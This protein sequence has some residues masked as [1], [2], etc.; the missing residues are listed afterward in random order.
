MNPIRKAIDPEKATVAT[1]SPHVASPPESSKA[2]MRLFDPVKEN[3]RPIRPARPPRPMPQTIQDCCDLFVK[4]K[5]AL[6]ALGAY[7]EKSFDRLK[8]S[9]A[10]FCEFIGDMLV[11]DARQSDL[12]DWLNTNTLWKNPH[13]LQA[14]AGY[15][16]SAFRFVAKEGLIQRCPFYRNA[17]LFPVA[18][19][20]EDLKPEEYQA[21]MRVSRVTP[22]FR[23][24]RRGP[25]KPKAE[26]R[27]GRRY[28][29]NRLH[30]PSSRA[31]RR[32][33]CF[34][35]ETGARVGE[36]MAM[37]WS[38]VDL[39]KSIV[40]LYYHK[41]VRKS[42]DSRIIAFPAKIKRLFV[43]TL[44]HSRIRP[45]PEDHVF[46]NGRGYPWNPVQFNQTFRKRRKMAG[47][48]R[49]ISAYSTRHGFC[50]RALEAGVPQRQIA[51]MM[52]QA[53]TRYVAWY[54]KGARKNV[55]Y[56]HGTLAQMNGKGSKPNFDG[57]AKGGES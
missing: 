7:S 41:T 33:F 19:P 26:A 18:M 55:E 22:Y 15:I 8:R 32:L 44:R 30:R 14:N 50:V 25:R 12:V 6:R 11:T 24:S 13:T 43:W 27:R 45:K 51:D 9:L 31:F 54:G 4:E 42:G 23:P 38:D 49:R 53:S 35:W 34:L 56:L 46:L 2:E 36:A 20:R 17:R 10:N 28:S 1:N 5:A 40:T 37:R 29:G 47:V 16:V 52:G 48:T 3:M 21:I 39:N 57:D